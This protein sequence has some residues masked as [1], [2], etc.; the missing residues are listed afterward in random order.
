MCK[1]KKTLGMVAQR[2]M[3][4]L[5]IPLLKRKGWS[6]DRWS[7]WLHP[8]ERSVLSCPFKKQFRQ[9]DLCWNQTPNDCFHLVIQIKKIR[10]GH[11]HIPFLQWPFR[12]VAFQKGSQWPFTKQ[13]LHLLFFSL[14]SERVVK[15]NSPSDFIK[16]QRKVCCCHLLSHENLHMYC[17]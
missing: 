12:K 7:H 10:W 16:S 2:W 14:F 8:V 11:E 3:D 6:Q 15:R 17:L 1:T 5:Y 13:K 4:L 9:S